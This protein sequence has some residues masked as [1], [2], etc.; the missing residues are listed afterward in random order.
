MIALHPFGLP[1]R[2]CLVYCPHP[3]LLTTKTNKIIKNSKQSKLMKL[4]KKTK[5]KEEKK[6]ICYGRLTKF[7]SLI[8]LPPN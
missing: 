7:S 1:P 4:K 8:G 5:T 6:K 2:K 3:D